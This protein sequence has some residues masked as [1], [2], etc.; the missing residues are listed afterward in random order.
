MAIS[1]DQAKTIITNNLGESDAATDTFVGQ[2]LDMAQRDVARA[3][4]WPEMFRRAFVNTVAAYST[5]T[6][7]VTYNSRTVTLTT[8]TWPSDVASAPYRFALGA[9]QQWYQ[10][11]TRSSDSIIL[12]SQA[13]VGDTDSSTTYVVYKNLLSLE[14]DCDKVEAVFLHDGTRAVELFHVPSESWATD[15]G[16][17]PSGTGVP[18]RYTVVERDGSGYVQIMVGPLVPDDVYRVE[19]VYRKAIT[20]GTLSL[21][22][23]LN[24]L[25]IYRAQAMAYERDHFQRSVAMMDRWPSML[26]AEIARTGDVGGESFTIGRG[27]LLRGGDYL[28]RLMD[29]GT[30]EAS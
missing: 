5:G 7:A 28:D 1:F 10:V 29:F 12:L 6:V 8:G 13:Y 2:C 22:E 25:V 21:S 16:H 14:S 20:E 24:D 27:R 4:A 18:N 17:F 30:V 9:G 11:A 23:A 26:A 3:H 15:F 19:Y